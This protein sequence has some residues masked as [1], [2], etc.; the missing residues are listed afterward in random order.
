MSAD[1]FAARICAEV[2]RRGEMQEDG[3][4]H[5][6]LEDVARTL[7]PAIRVELRAEW[8]AEDKPVARPIPSRSDALPSRE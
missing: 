5:R 6:M 8:A 7:F 2:I 3:H 4:G 1:D